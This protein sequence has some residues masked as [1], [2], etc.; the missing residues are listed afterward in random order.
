MGN[1]SELMMEIDTA[2][3]HEGPGMKIE[4]DDYQQN[5]GY[6]YE[7]TLKFFVDGEHV[8]DITGGENIGWNSN[9]LYCDYLVEMVDTLRFNHIEVK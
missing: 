7:A 9:D 6:N 1:I 5:S 8:A 4:V 3:G 2:V